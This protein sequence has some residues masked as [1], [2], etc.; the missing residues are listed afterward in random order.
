MCGDFNSQALR[1]LFIK[2]IRRFLKVWK[3]TV[4]SP[5][6]TTS[7]YFLVFGVA[8]GGRLGDVDG[9][10]YI[11]F[12]IPGLMMLAM[13]SNAFLN[14]SSSLFQ[15]KINGT[16]DDILVAPIGTFEILIAY[17]GAATC[18]GLL[19]GV[20]VWLV[21]LLFVGFN[22]HAPLWVLF[23]A[24]L[25]CIAFSLGGLL[26]AMWAQKFDHLAI[27]PSFVI[28]PLTFLGGVFYSIDMLPEFWRNLSLANPVLYMV[29]GLRYALLGSSDVP[30]HVCALVLLALTSAVGAAAALA[31]HRRWNLRL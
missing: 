30:V 24:L 27:V 21:A 9:V 29:N 18:R 14:T 23:F 5:L 11:A 28:T 25:V 31:F 7:L 12:V 3:Q 10:P 20:L 19:V 8:L 1:T 16:I 13:I 22:L 26:I 2:E 15:S 6:I 17:V 4:F